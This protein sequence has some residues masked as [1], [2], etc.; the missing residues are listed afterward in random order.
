MKNNLANRVIAIL[1][2]KARNGCVE[3]EKS[4]IGFENGNGTEVGKDIE[5]L[6][7]LAKKEL[8]NGK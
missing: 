4:W 3:K 6:I 2:I 8:K 7:K 5:R 1:D